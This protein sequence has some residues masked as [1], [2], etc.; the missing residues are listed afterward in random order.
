MF[1]RKGRMITR[2]KEVRLRQGNF[3]QN[4]KHDCSLKVHTTVDRMKNM[5]RLAV[6]LMKLNFLIPALQNF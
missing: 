3:T 4:K 5:A 6:T 1:G 2:S